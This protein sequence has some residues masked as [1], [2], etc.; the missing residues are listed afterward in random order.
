MSDD[1]TQEFVMTDELRKK[2]GE[3]PV[4]NILYVGDKDSYLS[5][6]R[7]ESMLRTFSEVYQTQAHI[8]YMTATPSYLSKIKLSQ[9]ENINILWIDNVS[10]FHAAQKLNEIQSAL[11]EEIRPGWREEVQALQSDGDEDGAVEL[12]RNINKER[13]SKLKI[14]YSIDEWVWEGP[15]GRAHD[16]QTVQVMETYINMADVVVTPTQELRDAIQYYKFIAD[17]DKPI[18]NIQSALNSD[19]FQLYRDFSRKGG[20]RADQLRSKP[21]VLIKGISMPENVQQFVVDNYKKMDITVC[22]VGEVNDHLMGLM[23]NGKVN[24][25][26]H[27]ANPFVNRTNINATYSIERDGSYDFVIHT[28]PDNLVGDLYEVTTGDEDILFAIAS[29]ALPICGIDHLGYDEN[30]TNLAVTAGLTFGK[31]TNPK[32]IR[33]MIE[34]HMVPVTFNEK[35][36]RCRSIVENRLAASPLIGSRY[37]SLMLSDELRQARNVLADESKVKEESFQEEQAARQSVSEATKTAS[38]DTQSDDDD[39]VI[40]V[41]FAT[42]E[43]K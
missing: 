35:F 9:L 23:Q 19:F 7:G 16:I 25:I 32:K 4:F 17:P 40:A 31:D 36:N 10:D 11:L 21:K 29:G 43:V 1:N 28:K 6:F 42:G 24:H 5:P 15:I 20:S 14:I 18:W 2:A 39:K 30:S 38:V 27:W 13:E 3:R 26:Y 37:F 33:Q 22:S 12:I 8:S 41:D 34:A